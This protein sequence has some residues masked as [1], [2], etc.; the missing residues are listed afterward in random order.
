MRELEKNSYPHVKVSFLV[1]YLLKNKKLAKI[2][3]FRE[4]HWEKNQKNKI[5]RSL[6]Q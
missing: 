4:N 6:I 2:N 3:Y 1:K 5:K